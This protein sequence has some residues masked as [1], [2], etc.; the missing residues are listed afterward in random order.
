M[1]TC[2]CSSHAL[3]LVTFDNGTALLRCPAHETQRWLV[4]GRPADS[5]EALSALRE[6]FV[7]ERTER[8]SRRRARTRP[9]VIRLPEPAPVQQVTPPLGVDDASLTALL[10]ARG[11]S[12]TWA[13]A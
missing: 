6:L 8:R 5:T 7:Q 11:L 1:S 4:D 13:I 3:V 2:P 10:Q 12:G 9:R